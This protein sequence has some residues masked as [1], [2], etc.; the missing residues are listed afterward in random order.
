MPLEQVEELR[1]QCRARAIG[2]EVREKRI[3]GVF[4]HKR[5]V[6]AGGEPLGKRGFARADRSFD[7]DV[8]ELQVAPMISSAA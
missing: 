7:R 3:L 8:A 4:E 1:L 6:E 2:I 5:G